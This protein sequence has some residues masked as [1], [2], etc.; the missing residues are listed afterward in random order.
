M[1]HYVDIIVT[2]IYMLFNKHNVSDQVRE[3]GARILSHR[4]RLDW[5]VCA[6]LYIVTLYAWL[7]VTP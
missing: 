1:Y 5:N 2:A 7:N 4:V 3:R 6:H